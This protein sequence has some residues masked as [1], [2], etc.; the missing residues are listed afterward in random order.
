[1]AGRGVIAPPAGPGVTVTG[2]PG[3]NIVGLTFASSAG[4]PEVLLSDAAGNTNVLENSFIDRT[5]GDANPAVGIRTTSTGTPRIVGNSFTLLQDA[6]EVISPTE[7][8]PGRPLITANIIGGV[9]PGGRGILVTSSASHTL[10]GATTAIVT[11]NSISSEAER[12][13]GVLVSDGGSTAVD[14]VPPGAG[15][16]MVGNRLSGLTVGLR[17]LGG[18]AS[19]TSFGDVIA[20]MESLGGPAQTPIDAGEVNDLGGDLSVTNSDLIDTFGPAVQLNNSR[21]TL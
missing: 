19:V 4:G 17:D 16:A 3:P 9:P 5:P 18:R 8:A 21:L 13:A 2:G 10:T 11:G 7:G 14:P 1:D 15:V 12:S 6:V 20:T